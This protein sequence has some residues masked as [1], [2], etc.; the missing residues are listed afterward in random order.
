MIAV[1]YQKGIHLPE[2]GLWLDPHAPRD[3][4]FVSHAH[5]DHTGRHQR[6]ICT[7]P[8]ARLMQVRMGGNLG[9]LEILGYGEHRD[10]GGWAATLLP[11]GHV[12]GSAQLYYESAEGTL[13]Y[14]GDFKLRHGLS[15]E[16]ATAWHAETLIM[17]TTYGLPRYQFPPIAQVEAEIL[18]FCHEAL[19][20]GETPVL[21]GY[22]L[23]KAQEILATLREAGLKIMLHGAIWKVAQVYEEFGFSFPAYEPYEKGKVAGHVLVCPP[24]VNGSK[25]L[26]QIGKRRVAVLTGWAIDAGAWRRLQVDAAFPL[27]D[28]A[29]YNDLLRHVEAVKPQ[30]VLTL[31][32]FAQEFARDLRNRGIEAW[33]LMGANQLELKIAANFQPA[34]REE[35][36]DTP[37]ENVGFNAFCLVCEA[38]RLATGKLEKVRLLSAYLGALNDTELPLAAV[39]LT[40]RPFAQSDGRNLNAGGAVIRRALGLASGLNTAEMKILSR[41]F[42]DSGLAATE[43]MRAKPGREVLMLREI[44]ETFERIQQARGPLL[45]TEIVTETL[46]RMPVVAAGYIVRIM[47]GDLRIGLKEGLLEDA[48]AA[49]FDERPGA[50]RE[51]HML[52]GDVGE[53]ALLARRHKLHTAELTVFQPVKCMLAGPEPDGDAVW[54]RLGASGSVW[55]EDKL[56]G[57]RAQLHCTPERAEIFSRDLKNITRTFPEIATAARGVGHAAVFDGEILAWE[58]GRALSF[59]ELQKRLGRHEADLFLGS[60]IPVA[61]V[62]FDLLSIE[63]QSLLKSPL[64]QRREQLERLTWSSPLLLAPVQKATSAA[65]IE[66]AFLAARERGN[67]GLMAKHPESAY[68]PGRRGLS[69]IKLKRELATLDVVVVAVEYGHGRRSKVLSD[70]TFAVRDDATGAL[71]NIGKAYSGLTDLE[72][73]DLT[74][75]FLDLVVTREGRV[76]E[77]EP[78]IVLEISFDSIQPSARHASGLALRFPRIKRLRR[79]KKP[80]D[81]DTLS[82]ARSLAKL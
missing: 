27:S 66:E 63:G 59:F 39:W 60:E 13:L 49:A 22:A 54:E 64:A 32:G 58:N 69:W 48:I 78:R 46:S 20:E 65:E 73:E 35:I 38:V 11:A 67:E 57:I 77:V 47:T 30:R 50:F 29:D 24:N 33:S 44:G 41:R 16:A 72:I 55:T 68:T 42:N 52:L 80:K 19:E 8:T 40:G 18:K 4:A 12:L 62:V 71:L 25:M 79:D 7:A 75:E 61:Y 82:A 5:S 26:A 2:S 10:F 31:H 45:K 9:N 70:Y 81:I 1:A 6:V 34:P 17:E 3:L 15:S 37:L 28:H 36:E 56:D 43:A 21:L 76:L 23:G 51:A 14:T 74:A 53:A